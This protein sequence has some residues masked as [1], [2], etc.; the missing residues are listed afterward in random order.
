M[1]QKPRR[2]CNNGVTMWKLK[3]VGKYRYPVYHREGG[4]AVIYEDGSEEWF[5]EGKFHREDGPACTYQRHWKETN[6]PKTEEWFFHGQRHREDGPAIIVKNTFKQWWKKGKP[7]RESGPAIEFR[8][9]N[10]EWWLNG[11]QYTRETYYRTL[12]NRKKITKEELFI[13]LI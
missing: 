13:N 9:G 12:Y 4:P 3:A 2:Y 10:K 11:K 7:H 5:F 1:K 6:S 8:N